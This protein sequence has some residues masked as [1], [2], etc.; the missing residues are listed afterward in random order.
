[1]RIT[2]LTIGSRGDVQPYLALGLGLKKAGHQVRLATNFT[3]A[4]FI[5]SRGLEFAPLEGDPKELLEGETGQLWLETS[6]NPIQFF[7]LYAELARP[8][9]E[10]QMNDSWKVCQDAEAVIYSPLAFGGYSIA[11]KLSIPGYRAVLQPAG[12]TKEFPSCMT[13]PEVHL[14]GIYNWFTHFLMEQLFWQPF[15]QPINDWVQS[16]LNLPP[17]PWLGFSSPT[18]QRKHPC[19]YGYSPSVLPK[20]RD[21]Q[22]WQHVTGYWFLERPSDWQPPAD[23]VD[24]LESGSPPVYIGFGSM[25]SSNSEERTELVLKSLTMAG[26]RGILLTGWGGLSNADL[27]DNV[28]KVESIPHDWLFPQMGLIVHHGGAGTTSA[29]LRAGVPTI[30]AP[31]FADQPFWGYRV[32]ELGVGPAPIPQKKLTAQKLAAA[33]QATISDEAMCNRARALGEKIRAE[34]GVAR[35]VEIFHRYLPVLS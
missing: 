34:D 12:R 5:N 1:M 28:F 33:I 29:S 7:R 2:I 20:P 9:I 16:T 10:H 30:I 22:E 32:K 27:P 19:L 14:G 3:F 21:W 23:L 6:G 24:F 31:F 17:L 26:K 18:Y 8:I 13:P 25:M 35:A 11:E 4:E 15:K